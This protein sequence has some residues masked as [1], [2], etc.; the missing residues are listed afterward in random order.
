MERLVITLF[1]SQ[2]PSALFSQFCV[3]GLF[4]V[5]M[6]KFFGNQYR[7]VQNLLLHLLIGDYTIV[8]LFEGLF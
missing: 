1:R 3:V 4:P 8:G 6:N 5:L 2:V 7:A